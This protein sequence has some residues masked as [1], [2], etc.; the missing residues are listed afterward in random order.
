MK[1][2]IL[3]SSSIFQRFLKPPQ[4]NYSLRYTSRIPQSET[5][6]KMP[7]ILIENLKNSYTM[8]TEKPKFPSNI[9]FS[10]LLPIGARNETKETSGTLKSIQNMHL[11]S[12]EA[13]NFAKLQTK[14]SVL[15]MNYGYEYS[16]Y[17]GYC[18]PCYLDEFLDIVKNAVFEM[19]SENDMDKNKFRHQ[20]FWDNYQDSSIESINQEFVLKSLFS[21]GL[22]NSLN[23]DSENIPKISEINSFVSN[24]F[25]SN[26]I[27][28]IS[29]L[30]NQEDSIKLANT[31]LPEKTIPV[32]PTPSSIFQETESWSLCNNSINFINLSF[33]AFPITDPRSRYLDLLTLL[34]NSKYPRL[35]VSSEIKSLFCTN[36]SFSDIGAFTFTAAA[37]PVNLEKAGE[38]L[39]NE[40]KKILKLSSEDFEY[41]KNLYLLNALQVFDEQSQR[42]E[43]FLREFLFTNKIT[44]EFETVQEVRKMNF[45]SFLECVKE[46][47]GNK[48][49][50]SVL[51]SVRREKMNL[52]SFI[53]N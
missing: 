25:Y 45:E 43:N 32:C 46:V 50:L 16:L 3:R 40:L 39:S 7:E 44:Q 13:E 49:N 42:T 31:L 35:Q 19:R 33:K 20:E 2:T 23:G 53:V 18:L 51:S 47:I 4:P 30:S 48:K 37:N 21:G 11:G 36:Y 34:Y 26:G 17:D 29:G 22:S 27:L 52:K 15:R 8:I 1:G 14:G 24:N 5:E 9:Y 12:K 41:C 6:L 38:Q 10:L 28:F